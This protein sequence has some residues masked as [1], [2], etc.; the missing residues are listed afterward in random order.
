MYAGDKNFQGSPAAPPVAVTILAPPAPVGSVAT[1]LTA[2]AFALGG[3]KAMTPFSLTVTATDARGNRV[4][5]YA[6][7]MT[8]TLVGTP[9]GSLLGATTAATTSGVAL[10]NLQVTAAGSYTFL[11][12]SGGLSL[13]FSIT[14]SSRQT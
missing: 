8:V 11:I 4:T 1:H 13:M 5:T 7:P 14:I 6:Q 10:F 2:S 12:T 9:P 3:L